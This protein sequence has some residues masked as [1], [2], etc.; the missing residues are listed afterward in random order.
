LGITRWPYR[1]LK[2]L[3][4]LISSCAKVTDRA[5]VEVKLQL[6]QWIQNLEAIQVR[7][8]GTGRNAASR[9]RATACR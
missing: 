6:D 7:G 1:K 4:N 2:S 8:D 5:S 9:A 3:R